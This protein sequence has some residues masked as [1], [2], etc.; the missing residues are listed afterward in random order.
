MSRNGGLSDSSTWPLEVVSILGIRPNTQPNFD[1]NCTT[2]AVSRHSVTLQCRE[3][4][5]TG[6]IVN[7]IH[8]ICVSWIFL[9]K[10]LI[11]LGYYVICGRVAWEHVVWAHVELYV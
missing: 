5:L 6:L 4:D 2:V 3:H 7:V 8:V 11:P 10:L 9:F 1:G